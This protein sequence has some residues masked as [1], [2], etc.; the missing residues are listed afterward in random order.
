MKM[1]YQRMN[2]IAGAGLLFP[3]LLPLSVVLMAYVA[4]RSPRHAL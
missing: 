1:S 2:E 4:Y 3:F